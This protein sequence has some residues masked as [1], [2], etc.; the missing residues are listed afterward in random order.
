MTADGRSFAS[1]AGR[2]AKALKIEAVLAT[3]LATPIEGRTILDVGCG[4]GH[5]AAHFAAKN[6]VTGVDAVDQTTAAEAARFTFV[7]TKGETLPFPDGSFDIALSNHVAAYLPSLDLH[8]AELFRVL[9]RGGVVYVATPNRFF[10]LEPHTR[11]PFLHWLPRDA[12]RA[13]LRRITGRDERVRIPSLLGLRRAAMRAGF[14][15]RDYTMDIV[16]D[17]ARFHFEGPARSWLPRAASLI[18]P[19]VILVL[20]R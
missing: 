3:H 4:S 14:E 9:R 17:P 5:I 1:A 12:Y 2:E 20:S 6:R 11:K 7:L 19:T 8:L 18:S 10:P 15:V 13:A 16:R